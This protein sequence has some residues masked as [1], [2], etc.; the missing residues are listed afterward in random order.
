[1]TNDD[2]IHR[3]RLRL[4]A[5]AQGDGQRPHRLPAVGRPPLDLL[6]RGFQAVPRGG[7]TLPTTGPSVPFSGAVGHLE[8]DL[9]P[10]PSRV[11]VT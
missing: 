2:V 1:L 10:R 8:G 7:L 6:L 9:R 3:S 5:L 4:F 11:D